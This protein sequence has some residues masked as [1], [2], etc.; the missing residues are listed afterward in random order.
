MQHCHALGIA[1]TLGMAQ[2]SL[3]C[4]QLGVAIED[5]FNC[6][7]LGRG[8]FLG[9]LSDGEPRRYLNL[10]GIGMKLTGKRRQQRRLAAAVGAND[11]DALTR[12]NSQ[13]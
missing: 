12:V 6:G 10:A 13:G 11:T 9:N 8:R 2:G 3:G 7:E 4:A 5:M 1:S